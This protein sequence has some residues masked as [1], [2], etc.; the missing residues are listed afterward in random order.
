MCLNNNNRFEKWLNNDFGCTSHNN[1]HVV[2][3]N[4][5]F[6]LFLFILPF[7]VNKDFHNKFE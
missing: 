1:F 5:H 4:H 2:F 3:L 7:V 6:C